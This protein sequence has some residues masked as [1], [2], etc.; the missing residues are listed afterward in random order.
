MPSY[1]VVRFYHIQN[2]KGL[3]NSCSVKQFLSLAASMLLV[4]TSKLHIQ[5]CTTKIP[6]KR[7]GLCKE[8]WP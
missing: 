6:V 7:T 1:E 8:N 4:F 2:S 3:D 5:Y